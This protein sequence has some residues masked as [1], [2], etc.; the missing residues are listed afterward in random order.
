MNWLIVSTIGK[1]PGDEFIKC[2]VRNVIKRVDE[3]ATGLVLDKETNSIHKSHDFDKCIWAGMPVFWSL[4]NNTSWNVPWWNVLTRGWVSE[5]KDDFC[6]LGAGSFQD[7]KDPVRGLQQDKM[8][9]EAK[10]LQDRS[11]CVVVRDPVACDI[12]SIDFPVKVCP[13]ILSTYDIEKTS[14]IKACNLMPRGA[15]YTQFN[16]NQSQHWRDK[17]QKIANIL[18]QNNF[19]F[20]A[21]ND[22]EYKHAINLGWSVDDIV[23]YN[24]NTSG[25]LNQYRNVDKFF[26]NRVHGCIVARANGADVISCGYD[27]R[28]EAVRLSGAD[29]KSPEDLNLDEIEKWA[30]SEPRTN[31]IDLDEIMNWYCEVLNN[32]TID[33]N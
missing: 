14:S 11:H 6:V 7:W 4:Y 10:L 33:D 3:H 31:P 9:E 1:N 32:F 16:E 15:H 28:Q 23:N 24:K 8:Q 29:V 20:F 25:M 13:A 22:E 27:S 17:Q 18:K 2:G 12:T 5:R 26:G 21:H 19:T 30:Q